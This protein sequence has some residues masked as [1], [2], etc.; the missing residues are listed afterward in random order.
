L[1][2]KISKLG[3]LTIFLLVWSTAEAV[4]SST[5]VKDGQ[6]LSKQMS[7]IRMEDMR[8]RKLIASDFNLR[9]LSGKEVKLSDF[10]GKVV[11]LNFFATW[12]GSC[13]WE[14][15]EMEKLYRAYKDRGFTVLAVS[16][17]FAGPE[18]V[19]KFAEQRNL[20]FPIVMDTDKAVA[21]E[22]GL[23]GPP[24]SYLIDK[25]GRIVGGVLGPTDWSDGDAFKIVEHFL[26]S[27]GAS[28]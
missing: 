3:L 25:K 26:N 18:K 12:C 10:R 17:D 14:M 5:E 21:K 23:V 19:K 28:D 13:V 8:E 16:L 27:D 2:K 6:A 9:D 20:T 24:L 22:Y 11:L 1:K 15:P 7:G 4:Q